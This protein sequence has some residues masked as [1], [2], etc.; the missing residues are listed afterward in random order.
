MPG[1]KHKHFRYF[2]TYFVC[3][4]AL[5]SFLQLATFGRQYHSPLRSDNTA[6]SYLAVSA[7]WPTSGQDM[8]SSCKI[9][10]SRINREMRVCF[11]QPDVQ[12]AGPCKRLYVDS[13]GARA[14]KGQLSP[15][16]RLSK[17]KK[18][19]CQIFTSKSWR[20]RLVSLLCLGRTQA[21]C[22]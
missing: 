15:Y 8:V 16:H 13:L 19:D 17:Q 18:R 6:Y 10:P 14:L 2:A 7:C 3:I 11:L 9:F 21:I 20:T 1:D 5:S 22:I 12:H 4:R